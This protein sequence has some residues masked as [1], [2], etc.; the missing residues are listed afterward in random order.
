MFIS[1]SPLDLRLIINIVIMM[2]PVYNIEDSTLKIMKV[3]FVPK[4]SKSEGASDVACSPDE[5]FARAGVGGGAGGFLL[6]VSDH[7]HVIRRRSRCRRVPGGEARTMRLPPLCLRLV[8][9]FHGFLGR[10]RPAALPSSVSALSVPHPSSACRFFFA[11]NNF[12]ACPP[13]NAGM[14]RT[15]PF[16]ETPVVRKLHLLTARLRR[17]HSSHM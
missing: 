5:P 13:L 16:H 3:F 1:P 17:Q 15:H 4:A 10:L 2:C 14:H 6:E 7:V 11:A 8:C 12:A 9:L